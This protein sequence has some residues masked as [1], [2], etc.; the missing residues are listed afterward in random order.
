MKNKRFI[1]ILLTVVLLLCIPLIAMQFTNQVDWKLSDFIVIGILL[2]GTGTVIEVVLR[3]VKNQ[4]TRIGMV[5]GILV[6]LF[7]VWAELAV[8]VFG[9]PFAGS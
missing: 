7:L 5:L 8:G 9:T 1:G 4:R 2:L 6:V 3:N